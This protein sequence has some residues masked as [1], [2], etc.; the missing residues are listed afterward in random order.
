MNY[1]MPTQEEIHVAFGKG[2]EAVL[3]LFYDVGKQM[4]EL[5]GQLEKQAAALKELQAWQSKNSQNSSK[6]PSSDG[7][8]KPK[9]TESL[10]KPGQKP[11]G[12]QPGHKGHTLKP[13]DNP[14]RTEAHETGQC[15]HCQASLK[16]VKPTAYEERQ[17]YDIPAIRIEVTAHCAEIKICPGCGTENKGEFPEGVKQPVQYGSGF[18]TWAAYFT[19]QH[20]IPVERTAQI[21]EDLLKH[22][23]SEATILKAG[24]ELSEQISPSVETV[25]DQLRKSDVL[26]LDES[27]L[28]VKSKLHCLHVASTDK[29]T[30]YEVHA[31]RGKEA[32]DEAGIL[33]DFRGRASKSANFS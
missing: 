12:G 31:K 1:R 19:D 6:P 22:R 2:E 21:F 26:N 14:D 8:N 27:G 20:F 9:R 11:N 15:E 17:V 23:P 28:R 24:E 4:E 30:Y 13:S 29:L 16:E 10:R 25:K 3:E 18:K 32:M 7:Y 33:E 5:A